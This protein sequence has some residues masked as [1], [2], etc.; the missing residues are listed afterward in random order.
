MSTAVLQAGKKKKHIIPTQNVF[1]GVVAAAESK[2]MKVN[3]SKTNM[4]CIHDSM[5]YVPETFIYDDG[6]NEIKNGGA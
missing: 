5:S 3:C 4:L 1:Q 6:G 2:G